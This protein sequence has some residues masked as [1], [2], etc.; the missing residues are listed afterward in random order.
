M[1]VHEIAKELNI[2]SKEICAYLS[3]DSKN[4]TNFSGLSDDEVKR[5]RGKYGSD[6]KSQ[7]SENKDNV[8][9]DSIKPD[10]NNK[11]RSKTEMN[12]SEEK[13]NRNNN[14]N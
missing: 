12:T 4:F 11:Q 7:T 6:S 2:P 13:K 3:T 5:V 10:S 1:R 14:D 9:K 8:K